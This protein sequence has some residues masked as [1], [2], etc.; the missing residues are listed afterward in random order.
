MKITKGMFKDVEAVIVETEKL[1]ATFLPCLGAKFVSLID[2]RTGRQYFEQNPGEKY[3]KL[4]Y[5]GKYTDA[6][7]S[8]FDDMFPTIDAYRSSQFPWEGTELPDHGEVCGL[9]WNMEIGDDS[10]TFDVYGVRFPYHM[11]KTVYEKNG[12]IA[13]SYSVENLSPFDMDFIYASHCMIKAEPGSTVTTPFPD[14]AQC[15]MIFDA[16]YGHKYGDKYSW[17]PIIT[18]E[19]NN[20]TFKFFFDDPVSE[21]WAKYTYPDG[22]YIKMV[23]DGDK[24]PYLAIWE[25]DG[26]LLG[27]HNCAFEP[28]SGT[29]DRP[30]VARMHGKFSVLP[31]KGCFKWN[32]GFEVR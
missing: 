21:G 16:T 3:R 15:T 17:K 31:A 25:N 2:T 4:S 11:T 30:D 9:P 5:A 14:G 19:K 27:M 7:C 20:A 28:C 24:L 6:E 8:A 18:P 32:E 1:R 10:V 13:L 12:N 26:N 23:F 29:H 22:D